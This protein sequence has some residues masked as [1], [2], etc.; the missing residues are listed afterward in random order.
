MATES[1]LDKMRKGALERI[2][3]GERNFKAAFFFAA[4]L[5]ACFLAGFLLLAD[6]HNR[7]HLLLLISTM[8]VYSIVGMGLVALGSY[9]K[10]QT[11]LILQALDARE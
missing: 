10:K 5:E 1:D 2:E 9:V 8:A 6:L 11:H 7:L 4:L 3:R